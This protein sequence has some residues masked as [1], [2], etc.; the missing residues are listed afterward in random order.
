MLR[1]KP[2]LFEEV[3]VSR[4]KDAFRISERWRRR[5]E[6]LLNSEKSPL[7]AELKVWEKRA[8]KRVGG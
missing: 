3:E 2:V 5:L 4:S 1:R 7:K 8:R 6:M